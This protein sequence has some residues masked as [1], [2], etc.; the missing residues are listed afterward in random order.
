MYLVLCCHEKNFIYIQK[1]RSQTTGLTMTSD[2]LIQQS[3]LGV[4]WSQ[5][6]NNYVYRLCFDLET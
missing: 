4:F 6:N 3:K 1:C 2:G 5:T